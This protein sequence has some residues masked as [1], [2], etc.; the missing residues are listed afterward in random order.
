MVLSHVGIV[1]LMVEEVI[2]QKIYVM[3][4]LKI[5]LKNHNVELPD[6]VGNFF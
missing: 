6:D 4:K 2:I 5:K 3:A 1:I